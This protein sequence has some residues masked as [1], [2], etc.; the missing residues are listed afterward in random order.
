MGIFIVTIVNTVIG[1]FIMTGV[2]KDDEQTVGLGIFLPMVL[3][4]LL[5]WLTAR[6]FLGQFDEAVQAILNGMVI[7]MEINGGVPMNGPPSFHQ[8]MAE[9]MD[10]DDLKKA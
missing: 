10:E 7:D 5:S 9:I 3:I 6:I 1:Y 2:T 4:F 8:K